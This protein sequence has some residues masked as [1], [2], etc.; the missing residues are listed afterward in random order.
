MSNNITLTA[1]LLSARQYSFTDDSN[2]KLEGTSVN[3]ALVQDEADRSSDFIGFNIKKLSGDHDL[4]KTI[5]P[6][7]IDKRVLVHCSMKPSG[8][9]FSF[10]PLSIELAK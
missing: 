9:G 10:K 4:F 3:I 8:T 6:D 1:K 2:K 7:F 5:N